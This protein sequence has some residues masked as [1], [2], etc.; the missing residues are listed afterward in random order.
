MPPLQWD[1]H[2]FRQR[3][4]QEVRCYFP[5]CKML[6]N[7]MVIGGNPA[8]KMYDVDPDT[9]EI[10][11]VKVYTSEVP[12]FV[13]GEQRE[14]DLCQAKISDPSFQSSRKLFRP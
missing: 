4:L 14:S 7:C 5:F 3:S 1:L 9:F 6:A 8:F 10:M 12:V 2:P 11:D 13:T